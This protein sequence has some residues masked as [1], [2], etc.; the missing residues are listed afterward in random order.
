MQNKG[1][2]FWPPS[3]WLGVELCWL[4][5]WM[6]VIGVSQLSWWVQPWELHRCGRYLPTILSNMCSNQQS[7]LVEAAAKLQS[8]LQFAIAEGFE[9]N[10]HGTRTIVVGIDARYIDCPSPFFL[11]SYYHSKYLA[12]WGPICACQ[13]RSLVSAR[14]E[15]WAVHALRENVPTTPITIHRCSGIWWAWTTISKMRH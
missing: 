10:Q 11:C 9:T 13:W 5:S 12:Q 7:Q 6:L 1:L 3:L 15:P 4:W 2:S 14:H 8:L